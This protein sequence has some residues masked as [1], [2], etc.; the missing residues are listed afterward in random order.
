MLLF[1]VSQLATAR[2]GSAIGWHNRT[3][4]VV[5]ESG[6]CVPASAGSGVSVLGV[7]V[8]VVW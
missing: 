8:G 3:D 5:C 7:W 6:G 2:V 4:Q 1:G